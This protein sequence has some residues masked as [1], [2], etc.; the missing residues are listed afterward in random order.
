MARHLVVLT[1]PIHKD[2]LR[3]LERSEGIDIVLLE[4]SSSNRSLEGIIRD[5][6]AILVRIAEIGRSLIEDSSSLKVIA[7]HGVG[8]DN[9]D[10]TAA[11]EKR[12]PV[13]FTPGSNANTVAEH[14]IGFLLLMAKN[15]CFAHMAVKNG[16]F[17]KRESFTGK[18]LYEKSLGIIGLGRIGGALARKCLK[19]FD[20]KVIAFDPFITDEYASDIG[21]EL[22][23]DL[24]D[25]LKMSDFVSIHAP[26]T[27]MTKNLIGERE[28]LMMRKTAFIFNTARGGIINEQ[29][30]CK[31]LTER[32]IAGA[33]LDVFVN[34]PPTIDNPLLG[35]DNVIVTPHLG[36]MTE[37]AMSRAAVM[38]AED[39]LRVLDGKRPEH[40]I[41]PEIYD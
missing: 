25:L 22:V 23:G 4:G 3:I 11:T 36:G 29:A 1:E 37:E 21:A 2:G 19:A 31:A 17:T 8:Y 18:E 33:A 24:G 15:L 30:L 12:I 27:A 9:I 35:L 40:I 6:N 13:T 26:L 38:A 34:E 7:K 39:I 16:K 14:T 10:V 41:N 28:L 20:M 5:A 32:W